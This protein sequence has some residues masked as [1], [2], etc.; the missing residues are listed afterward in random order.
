MPA[1]ALSLLI[2]LAAPAGPGLRVEVPADLAEDCP[3][4]SSVRRWIEAS[5]DRDPFAGD[6]PPTIR[7]A[8]RRGPEGVDVDVDHGPAGQRSIHAASCT[9]ALRAAAFSVAVALDP[10]GAAPLEPPPE[11]A[12]LE[13]SPERAAP[14]APTPT[15]A[16]DG[17]ARRRAPVSAQPIDATAAR[18]NTPSAPAA[19]GDPSPP[20]ALDLHP[21]LRVEPLVAAGHRP[22][23]GP[24]LRLGGGLGGDRWELGAAFTWLPATTTPFEGGEVAADLLAGELSGGLRLDAVDVVALALAGR[25]R[26]TGAGFDR[27]GAYDALHLGLGAGVAVRAPLAAG[28][29]LRVGLEGLWLPRVSRFTVSGRTAWTGPPVAARL[30]VGLRWSP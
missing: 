3:E 4:P 5:L 22:G 27:D 16:D 7:V 25:Q 21:H 30:S 13:A 18:P 1:L 29:A 2:G 11:P 14:P 24:G 9:A 28:L 20:E 8:A 19:R 26:G 12:T 6:D 23:P 10:L 15:P 17:R